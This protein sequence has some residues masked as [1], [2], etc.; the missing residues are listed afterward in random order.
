TRRVVV[1]DG[2]TF[3]R[4]ALSPVVAARGVS[5]TQ[6][7]TRERHRKPCPTATADAPC[8]F[9]EC[10]FNHV[11]F[12]RYP[13]SSQRS[14]PAPRSA[15]KFAISSYGEHDRPLPRRKNLVSTQNRP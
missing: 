10:H 12:L 14:R 15:T 1:R 11:L 13:G 9:T 7:Q 3:G 2:A 6:R 4:A 5:T 8:G